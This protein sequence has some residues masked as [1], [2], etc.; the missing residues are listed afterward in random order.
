VGEFISVLYDHRIKQPGQVWDLCKFAPLPDWAI[1]DPYRR[2][3]EMFQGC[4][5]RYLSGGG[6]P[7]APTGQELEGEFVD[8]TTPAEV[9]RGSILLAALTENENLPADP[10]YRIGVSQFV[11]PSY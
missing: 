6:T 8:P 5:H 11:R 9:L 4:L 2:R 10:D 3:A 1:V 7:A